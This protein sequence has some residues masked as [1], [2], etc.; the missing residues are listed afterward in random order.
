[1]KIF[2]NN[3]RE[4]KKKDE[5]IK[6]IR[7]AQARD[8]DDLL[9]S[10]KKNVEDLIQEHELELREKDYELDHFKDNEVKKLR[11]D[12]VLKNKRIEVLEKENEMLDKVVDL[13]SD[14]VDVKG[15]INSLIEKLPE[16]NISSL[17]VTGN[18]D[19]K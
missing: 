11:G 15:L 5:E 16:V 4:L 19:K 13:N 17:T 10:H 12:L 14:I 8:T 2:S 7:R 1:M 18:N 6:D 3:E 9:R